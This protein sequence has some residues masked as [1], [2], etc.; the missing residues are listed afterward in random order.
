MVYTLL[1]LLHLMKSTPP[2]YQG[3]KNQCLVLGTAFYVSPS[4]IATARHNV[5]GDSTEMSFRAFFYTADYAPQGTLFTAG[6]TFTHVT[7]FFGS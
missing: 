4:I 3:H 5:D 6:P 7:F 2:D 1:L